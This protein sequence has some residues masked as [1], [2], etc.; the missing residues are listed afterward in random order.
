MYSFR[1]RFVGNGFA[2]KSQI[3]TA[4]PHPAR[5]PKSKTRKKPTGKNCELML[6]ACCVALCIAA[7]PAELVSEIQRSDL[8]D[9]ESMGKASVAEKE[10]GKHFTVVS[11]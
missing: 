6:V 11:N 7:S 1:P 4:S 5:E 8:N 2:H 10:E 3:A 9:G